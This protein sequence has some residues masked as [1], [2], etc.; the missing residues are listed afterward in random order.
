VQF[1]FPAFGT[2]LQQVY[3]RIK[4]Q[5]QWSYTKVWGP[6]LF[7]YPLTT[8]TPRQPLAYNANAGVFA[9]LRFGQ[10]SPTGNDIKL[11]ETQGLKSFTWVMA[12][13]D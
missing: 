12:C 8:D 6:W 7:S 11:P 5:D 4:M 10:P 2:A 13:R 1:A 9:N 3:L